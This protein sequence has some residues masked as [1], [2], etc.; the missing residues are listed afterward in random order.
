M[1]NLMRIG[2]ALPALLIGLCV[3]CNP[4]S[5]SML[6]M[7]FSDNKVE[8]EYKLFGTEKEIT[9]AVLATSKTRD[10]REEL[11]KADEELVD[12]VSMFMRKRCEENKHRLKLVSK[13]QVFAAKC[14]MERDGTLDP[15]EL[16]HKVKAD[17]VLH[18]E[19]DK[20]ELY[21]PKCYPK[22]FQADA[23]I[24]ISLYRTKGKEDDEGN[25]VFGP[26]NYMRQ[27]PENKPP[28]PAEGGNPNHFRRM[29]MNVAGQEISRMFIAYPPEEKH[30]SMD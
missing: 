25:L 12:Q 10:L 4:Q 15:V 29:F 24:A 2:L 1:R 30:A 13:G 3:G 9:L 11:A 8:P 19:I 18:L 6:L 20:L 23:D 21:V 27:Y 16:G 14:N 5:L 22:M 28:I 26:K 17:Y 7:P